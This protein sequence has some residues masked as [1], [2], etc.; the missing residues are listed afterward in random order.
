MLFRFFTLITVLLF[1]TI[2]SEAQH[3]K[4]SF[5]KLKLLGHKYAEK[6]FAVHVKGIVI[7]AE[8]GERI[9]YATIILN[10]TEKGISTN[11]NGQFLFAT[12]TA[13]VSPEITISAI[14]YEAK[15]FRV[16]NDLQSEQLFFLQPAADELDK[17]EI[18]AWPTTSCRRVGT[19]CVTGT[20][21]AATFTSQGE[22]CLL[23]CG[24]VAKRKPRAETIAVAKNNVIHIYPNPTIAGN[25]VKAALRLQEPDQY[26]MDL[27][28]ASGRTVWVQTTSLNSP[29]YNLTI[30]TQSTWSAGVYWLR[31]TGS[32]T[33]R[34]YNSKIVLQ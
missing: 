23:M 28:D 14:G 31:I 5:G 11:E 27:V 2:G 30:P 32:Q 6:K 24:K 18:V 29:N 34:M 20:D 22:V 15:S 9:N 1:F 25:N 4:C 13:P 7:N 19:A 16:S 17:I 12:S 26:K 8:S 21:N 10:G 3:Y 33:N